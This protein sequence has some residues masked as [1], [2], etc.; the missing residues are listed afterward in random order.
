M[1]RKP[2]P[3]HTLQ[4][5]RY[6]TWY[7]WVVIA[8][9]SLF[10]FYKYVLQVSPSVMTN[11][12]MQHFHIAGT[13]LGNLAATFFYTYLVIQFFV[14]PLLDKYSTRYLAAIAIAVSGLGG[15]LFA[16]A[17]NLVEAEFSRGL[18]G[19]GAAFATVSY[20]KMAA[21]WFK[22]EQFAF[23]SGLL[24][25]AAMIGSMAGQAPLALLVSHIGWQNSLFYCG[26]GGLCLS[27]CY[28]LVVRDHP[29]LKIS[30]A[31]PVQKITLKD[32]LAL[33]RK[34]FN[35]LLML[36]SGLTFSPVAV[37]GGLWGVPFLEE[38][39][40]ITKTQA[41]SLTSLMFLGLA[42]GGPILGYISD[43]LG[44]RYPVMYF[45]LI[46]SLINLSLAIYYPQLNNGLTGVCLFLFGFGTGAFMLGFAIGKECNPAPLAATVIALI[47]TG[48]ALFGAFSEPLV[49][50]V[51]DTFWQGKLHHRTPYFSVHDFHLA[52]L[53]LPVYVI[54]ALILLTLLKRNSQ[55][56]ET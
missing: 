13:G 41:A 52:L 43:R 32:V 2:Q 39:H 4:S 22:P 11:A 38:A 29:P 24:A 47:N 21:V 16:R 30:N 46:L 37:F 36:Y 40:H 14:G 28:V 49:G 31:K 18:M 1:N 34:K 53:L 7:P 26:I 23:V 19:V 42:L 25:T 55:M 20:M 50:K 56:I 17:H 5:N 35:W 3:K 15:L 10:L 33:L 51:L 9:S 48:D 6:T 54:A 44:K 45:G 27:S 8:M 12:L